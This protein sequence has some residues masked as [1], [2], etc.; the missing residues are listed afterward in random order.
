MA[1]ATNFP[2]G[3]TSGGA[4]VAGAAA[5]GYKVARGSQALDG[6]NPTTVATGLTTVVAFVAT[7]RRNTAVSSGTAFVT[8]G[9]PSGGSVDVYGWVVAGTAST[10]TE[11]FDWVAV[12]T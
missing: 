3:L 9:T 2:D 1:P 11:V 5:A 8:I 12:G 6:S 4:A 10:G 7:L